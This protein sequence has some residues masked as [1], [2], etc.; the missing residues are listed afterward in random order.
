MFLTCK[1]PFSYFTDQY[2]A[3]LT[4]ALWYLFLQCYA[5]IIFLCRIFSPVQK[6][7][8][9][10]DGVDIALQVDL[11]QNASLNHQDGIQLMH[12]CQEQ[13][14]AYAWNR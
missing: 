6:L 7:N 1:N 5:V 14:I 12:W 11:P 8:F 10:F 2:R 9:N 13:A 3:V 4:F